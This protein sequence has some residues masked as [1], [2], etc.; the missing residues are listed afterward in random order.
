[1]EEKANGWI[2]LAGVVTIPVALFLKA[3]ALCYL[4]EWFIVPLGMDPIGKAHALGIAT[5]VCMLT[6]DH[7]PKSSDDGDP[8][9]K[10]LSAIFVSVFGPL[11]ALF[12]GWLAHLMMTA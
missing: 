1:M 12:F 3:F 2:A 4:W 8:F 11:F 5:V 10:M 9:A 7:T 6:P